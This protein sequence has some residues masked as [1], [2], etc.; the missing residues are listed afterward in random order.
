M[1]MLS[2][3]HKQ[4]HQE[5]GG[6]RGTGCYRCFHLLRLLLT[7]GVESGHRL[8]L[9]HW[10]FADGPA[11]CQRAQNTESPLKIVSFQIE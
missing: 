3:W 9:H 6:Q 7:D 10:S 11:M 2:L 1:C 8:C 4:G 5:R